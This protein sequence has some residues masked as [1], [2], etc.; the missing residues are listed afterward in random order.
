MKAMNLP[1]WVFNV[2]KCR[3]TMITL[4]KSKARSAALLLFVAP[5][6]SRLDLHTMPKHGLL[7]TGRD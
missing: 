3:D 1:S 7:P 5:R 4:Y 2:F 6:R